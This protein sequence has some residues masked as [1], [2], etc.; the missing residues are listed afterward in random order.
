MATLTIKIDT[1]KIE[2]EAKRVCEAARPRLA[3]LIADAEGSCTTTLA[4]LRVW[5]PRPFMAP[6]LK[7]Q[8][9]VRKLSVVE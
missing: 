7:R 1:A 6:T 9:L 2:R 5:S 4:M 3:A 8:I